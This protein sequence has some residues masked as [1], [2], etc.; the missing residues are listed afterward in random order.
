MNK[1]QA[2]KKCYA[3]NAVFRV[4]V[5]D[6]KPFQNPTERRHLIISLIRNLCQDFL[7]QLIDG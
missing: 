1:P 4:D 5:N 7:K 6:I 3:F 2:D